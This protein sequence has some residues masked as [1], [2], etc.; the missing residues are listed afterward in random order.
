MIPE[1]DIEITN[2]IG[3]GIIDP[4]NSFPMTLESVMLVSKLAM[5]SSYIEK[6]NLHN[7]FNIS[8]YYLTPFI[9]LHAIGMT[10]KKMKT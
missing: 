2:A 6:N 8:L 7:L 9:K 5:I 3:R 4:F 10:V 1:G